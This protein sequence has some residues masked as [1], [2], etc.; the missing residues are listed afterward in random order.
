MKLSVEDVVIT[1]GTF[2]LHLDG[3]FRSGIHLITGKTGS[4][5]TT[6]AEAL[7]GI[8]SLKRGTV[9]SEGIESRMLAMQSAQNHI[10]TSTVSREIASWGADIETVLF[11]ADLVG[12]ENRQILSLSRGELKR[13][14]LMCI[15]TT[16]FDLLILDEPYAGLD[17]SAKQMIS[18][19]I[20]DSGS[21]ICIIL[22]HDLSSLPP[23]D[24]LWEIKQE[25]LY[26]RGSIPDALISWEM[27]PEPVQYLLSHAQ[28]PANIDSKSLMEAAC[29]IRESGPV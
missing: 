9:R 20:S 7:I 14:V 23:V 8:L 12:F 22:T 1:R 28:K 2:L 3:I 19:A 15:L 16:R 21:R 24:Y 5:K 29:R 4:G 13:I 18:D 27:A 10:T 6:L 17:C 26:F 25:R 11:R